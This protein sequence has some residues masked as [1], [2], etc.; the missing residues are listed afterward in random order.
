M[1]SAVDIQQ[2]LFALQDEKYGDFHAKLIPA[3]DRAQIIGVRTPNLRKMAK[4]IVKDSDYSEFL[5]DLPHQYLD[6]NTLHALIISEIKDY[7]IAM[8]YTEKFL[9]YIDNWATCDMFAP[10][11]FKKY[12]DLVYEK[13]KVWLN[14][15]HTYTVRFGIVTLMSNFLD[16]EFKPEMLDRLANIHSE[17]YYINMALAWCWC[18]SLI[19]QY[20]RAIGY[21]TAQKLPKWVHNKALQKARES[22][23]F[24]KEEKEYFKSLKV[25]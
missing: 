20:D 21:F 5:R 7:A 4:K 25:K 22:Y 15:S 12:P 3:V 6:E 2:E 18:E 16:E 19:K 24:T 1:M 9:P 23:R 10:K 13:I 8:D 17:E 14:S 11:V